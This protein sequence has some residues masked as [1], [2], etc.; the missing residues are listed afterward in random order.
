MC[1]PSCCDKSGGQRTGIAAVAVIIGAALVA[2]RIGPI[3]ADIIHTAVEVIRLIAL[4]TGLLVALAVVTWAVIVLIRWQLRRKA[5]AVTR[6]QVVTMYP[7]EHTEP[8][9]RPDCL[10]CGGTGTV[11]QAISGGHYQPSGCPVCEPARRA[12]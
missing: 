2:A 10:A 1:R 7:R 11:L 5:L 4:V 12:G 3:V 9:D 8:A 6:A